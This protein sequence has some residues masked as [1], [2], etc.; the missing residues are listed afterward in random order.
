MPLRELVIDKKTGRLRQAGAH[1]PDGRFIQEFRTRAERSLYVLAKGVLG[2]TFLSPR[3]H[4]QMAHFLTDTPLDN[5]PIKRRKL[6][7]VP[8]FHGK[9]LLGCNCLPLHMLIQPAETN[10]YFPGLPGAETRI[11]LAGE[12]LDRAQDHLRVIETT[13]E[14]N[15]LFRALWPHVVWDDAKRQ[16]KKWNE[17]ECIVP[18][19]REYPDPTIRAIGVGVAITGAH[20]NVLIED[21][22]TTAEA[23]NSEA[24]MQAA[25]N[26]HVAWRAL[27]SDPVRDL[28]FVFATRWAVHDLPGYILENDPTFE[29]LLR[30]VVE[31]GQPIW[32]EKFT[33]RDVESWKAEFGTLFPL[34]F[35]NRATDRTLVDFNIDDLRTCVLHTHGVEF[36]EDERDAR[37]AADRGAPPALA[38]FDHLTYHPL[39]P[40]ILTQLRHEHLWR[41]KAR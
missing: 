30:E 10:I 9:S 37:L 7:L 18:R 19:A 1:D 27:L 12:K 35:L 31:G 17:S 6:V 16:S 11:L 39:A 38:G 4:R 20:P 34:F 2:Y 29:V 28:Q 25:V 22:L 23:A 13:L 33:L 32:P 14:S 40:D 41:I 36:Y 26:C 15:A 8:R 24:V 21:D 5:A 3:L